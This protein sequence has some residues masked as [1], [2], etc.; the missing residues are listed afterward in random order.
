MIKQILMLFLFTMPLLAMEKP[1]G[2]PIFAPAGI[3]TSEQEAEIA[4]LPEQERGYKLRDFIIHNILEQSKTFEEA[5]ERIKKLAQV[6]V[7]K[8]A[9]AFDLDYIKRYGPFE[10]LAQQQHAELDAI[11]K[12]YIYTQD[13]WIHPSIE[14]FRKAIPAL[15]MLEE[16][17]TSIYGDD[18]NIIKKLQVLTVDQDIAT[19]IN[20]Y[21]LFE[22][23]IYRF[24]RGRPALQVKI[25]TALKIPAAAE[26]I[27]RKINWTII[28]EIAY[29]LFSKD[30]TPEAL[31]FL[32]QN[33][34]DIQDKRGWAQTGAA[35]IMIFAIFH[36]NAELVKLLLNKGFD[37]NTEL[38]DFQMEVSFYYTTSLMEAVFR[39]SPEIVTLLLESG[40][41][42]NIL[43]Y[44]VLGGYKRGKG[45]LPLIQ[46]IRGDRPDI[47]QLLLNNPF[48]Q[49]IQKIRAAHGA[50]SYL[51]VLPKEVMATAAEKVKP[52][53]KADPNMVDAFGH[54]ALNQAVSQA[55]FAMIQLLLDAGAQINKKD[56]KGVTALMAAAESGKNL[57]IVKLLI[58]KG[59]DPK[60]CDNEGKTAYFY[61]SESLGPDKQAI[62]DYLD[63]I[64]EEHVSY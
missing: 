55:D 49:Q 27:K 48:A 50:Q 31:V 2:R 17:I 54:T 28:P 38:L 40:A 21:R 62:L 3:L 44:S 64:L 7:Y 11:L 53:F 12:F 34:P 42:P 15:N 24:A 63:T 59:A 29:A 56:S 43:A 5:I 39:N 25:I 13:K 14:E 32:V 20:S 19:F 51:G 6:P 41:D 9:L 4:K 35:T 45:E 16:R 61:A 33:L 10:W 22:N 8:D 30:F 37:P 18:K 60:V 23:I 58:D 52:T 36:K 46:A 57:E 1:T 47:V 26:F